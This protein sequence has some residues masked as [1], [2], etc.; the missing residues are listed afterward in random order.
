MVRAGRDWEWPESDPAKAFY[1]QCWVN[2]LQGVKRRSGVIT[3]CF[4]VD[5]GVGAK[6]GGWETCTEVSTL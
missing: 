1:I 2:L 5:L 3:A 4:S 6:N